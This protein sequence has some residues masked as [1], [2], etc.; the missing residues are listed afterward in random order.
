MATRGSASGLRRPELGH[1]R[2]G[3]AADLCVW[4]VGGVEDAGVADLVA[5]LLWA[6]PGRRPRHVVVA[7]RVVVR[8]GHLVSGDAR[9]IARRLGDLL[10]ARPPR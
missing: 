10:A 4:D 8:D 5:G 1:L 6:G 9:S 3:A 7:G 2:P